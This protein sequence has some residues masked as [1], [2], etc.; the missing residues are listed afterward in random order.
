QLNDTKT[1]I[2][3]TALFRDLDDCGAGIKLMLIDAC[4]N[5]PRG[6]RSID[7]DKMPRA[8]KGVA[9]LFS[10]KG[11]EGAQ[12]T[13]M[14]GK[15]HGV[16]LHYV[17]EGLKGKARNRANAVTWGSLVEYVTEQVSDEAPK[18]LGKEAQQ[19]PHL[20][21]NLL[22]KSPVLVRPSSAVTKKPTPTK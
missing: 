1:M 9:A 8:G 14:G 17:I 19:T 3:L 4:R 7:L 6:T 10:C 22:G 11:G 16:F 2:E 12:E 18:L 21:A 13:K 15:G 20:I 5:K